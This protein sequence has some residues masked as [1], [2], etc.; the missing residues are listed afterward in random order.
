MYQV[1]YITNFSYYHFT[2]QL[3]SLPTLLMFYF[4]HVVQYTIFLENIAI[5]DVTPLRLPQIKVQR[6]IFSPF[7]HFSVLVATLYETT[8]TITQKQNYEKDLLAKKKQKKVFTTYYSCLFHFPGTWP[9]FILIRII[10]VNLMLVTKFYP[11]LGHAW[12]STGKFIY[13]LLG[14]Q[15]TCEKSLPNH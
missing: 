13:P 10:P 8:N 9:L 15:P 3:I 12:K 14:P 7:F 2:V 6:H 4:I 1:S 5:W 11:K